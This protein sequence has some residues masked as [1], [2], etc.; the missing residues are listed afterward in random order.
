MVNIKSKIEEGWLQIS[1]IV[2]MMGKPKEHL[3]TTLKSYVDNLKKDKKIIFINEEYAEPKQ[4]EDSALFT[5]FVELEVLMKGPQKVI[6]FCFDFM[7]SSVEVIEPTTIHIKNEELNSLFNDLQ[8]R[9]HKLDMITKNA[10]QK[11][12]IL[13]KNGAILVFNS[14]LLALNQGPATLKELSSL[15]KVPEEELTKFL[16]KV[17]KDKRVKLSGKKYQLA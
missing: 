9:L 3:E 16:E 8:A 7:P 12:Q 13:S 2:E 1:F 10:N 17:V 11:L 4:V 5:T 15:T 6:D 14:I